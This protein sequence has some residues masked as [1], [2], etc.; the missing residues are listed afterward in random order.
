MPVSVSPRACCADDESILREIYASTRAHDLA[1]TAWTDEQKAAFLR[2]Q[3]DAQAHHYRAHFPAAR[4]DLVVLGD[5]PS[6]QPIGRLY[7]D[8]RPTTI[9]VLDISLLPAHR[10]QG[11]GAKLMETILS[12]ARAS[13][14]NVELHVEKH[15]PARRLYERLGFRVVE[16]GEVRVLMRAS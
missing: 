7:V 15:N 9:A 10:G 8:R 2:M 12:E 6:G 3:F 13:A 14:R 4:F 1:R 11:I 16:D 5:E